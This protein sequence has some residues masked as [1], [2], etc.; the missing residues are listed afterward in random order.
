MTNDW[1]TMDMNSSPRTI[2]KMPLIH[3]IGVDLVFVVLLII[4]E[5]CIVSRNLNEK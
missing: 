4:L 3:Q 5:W 1:T 2:G